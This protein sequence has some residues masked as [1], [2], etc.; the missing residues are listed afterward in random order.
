MAN[1]NKQRTAFEER[2]SKELFRG[3][4]IVWK[5]ENITVKSG[6]KDAFKGMLFVT[7]FQLLVVEA[8]SPNRFVSVRLHSIQKIKKVLKTRTD[9]PIIHIISKDFRKLT[10]ELPEKNRLLKEICEVITKYAFPPIKELFAFKLKEQFKGEF[11]GWNIYNAVEDYTRLNLHEGDWRVSE[12]N[13]KHQAVETYPERIVV[14]ACLTDETIKQASR[15]RTHSR[16]IATVWRHPENQSSLSRASQPRKGL[17]GRR[18]FTDETLVETLKNLNTDSKVFYILDSRPKINAKAN[19]LTGGGY[20]STKQYQN[21]IRE[22]AK[23]ENIHQ[24]RNSMKQLFRCIWKLDNAVSDGWLVNLVATKWLDHIRAILLAAM[25]IVELMD[26][27]KTSVLVHCS[28]GWDRTAQMTALSEVMMDRYY[29]TMRGFAQLIEKEWLS[30]GHRFALRGGHDENM[31]NPKSKERSPVFLQFIDCVWQL[32]QQYPREF[33]FNTNFLITILDHFNSCLFGTFLGNAEFEREQLK[34]KQKTQSI[35]SLIFNHADY[36]AN[37]AY[38]PETF[39]LRPDLSRSKI[40]LWE[41]YYLRWKGLEMLGYYPTFKPGALREYHLGLHREFV[42]KTMSLNVISK[43]ELPE[44][45]LEEEHNDNSKVVD[46]KHLQDTTESVRNHDKNDRESDEKS[47]SSSSASSSPLS[48]SHSVDSFDEISVGNTI[49]K[50]FGSSYKNDN[51]SNK[52]DKLSPKIEVKRPTTPM[53]TQSKSSPDTS[54]GIRKNRSASVSASSLENN[55]DILAYTIAVVKSGAK[56]TKPLRKSMQIL[57]TKNKDIDESSSTTSTLKLS[58]KSTPVQES[59]QSSGSSSSVRKTLEVSTTFKPDNMKK[60]TTTTTTNTTVTTVTTTTVKENVSKVVKENL[61]EPT[62]EK[63]FT[64]TEI[65]KNN[66]TKSEENHSSS[67][68]T[69]SGSE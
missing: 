52:K 19:Q 6:T 23:I 56:P 24:M 1:K 33:E 55:D 32:T 41:S 46:Q 34:V 38:S 62:N 65:Q 21:T 40:R 35:W 12:W 11:D 69:G 54:E 63:Q 45:P 16:V 2:V 27:K 68:T 5:L 3:E 44:L 64:S 39:V 66:P 59:Q 58:S 60:M 22:F 7:N 4:K 26:T 36:F 48:H 17:T 28:D 14:P 67:D 10:L 47:L 25:R 43:S 53:G 9:G 18:S 13:L 20:E 42:Q 8:E 31:G 37:T 61:Q 50:V 49:S 51:S 15:F 30:F 29:R 57:E